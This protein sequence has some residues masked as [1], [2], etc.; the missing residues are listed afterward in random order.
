MLRIVV[1]AFALSV[2]AG[3]VALGAVLTPGNEVNLQFNE[4]SPTATPDAANGTITLGGAVIGK[5]GVFHTATFSATIVSSGIGIVFNPTEL[6][7]N[8]NTLILTGSAAGVYV[9]AGGGTHT[10][11]LQVTGNN[12]TFTDTN[13]TTGKKQVSQGTYTAAVVPGVALYDNFSAPLI[14]PDKWSGGEYAANGGV[15]AEGIRGIQVVGIQ[16]TALRLLS[17]RYAGTESDSGTGFTNMRLDFAHPT[18]VTAIRAKVQVTNVHVT[19]CAGNPAPSF[20]GAQ[21]GGFFFNTG[22]PTPGNAT[23][24]VQAVVDV[25]RSSNS[26][27]AASLLQISANVIQCTSSDCTSFS[28]LPGS[29]VSLGKVG[30]GAPVRLFVAWDQPNKRFLFQRAT[31]AMVT[32]PYTVS[33]ASGP[34]NTD[35]RLQTFAFVANCTTAPRPQALM[36]VQFA[37]VEVNTP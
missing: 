25:R 9:G 13:V 37:H 24:D 7:F 8:S 22:T 15:L 20:T 4:T 21:I 5:P 2:G 32:I 11:R 16:P 28:Q 1:T 6:Q 19:G 26:T 33:D 27:D 17:R 12:W 31:S 14:N 30:L 29:P 36:D 35:K 3:G 18:L 10:V 34:G 23:G